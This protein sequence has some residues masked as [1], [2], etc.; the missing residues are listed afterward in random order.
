MN[1]FTIIRANTPSEAF[2]PPTI[3]S[4]EMIDECLPQDNRLANH[5]LNAIQIRE[6]KVKSQSFLFHL[7]KLKIKFILVKIQT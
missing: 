3:V 4:Y 2:L 5:L 6:N 7:I 1:N